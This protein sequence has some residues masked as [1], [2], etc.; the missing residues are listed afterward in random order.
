MKKITFSIFIQFFLILW[1]SYNFID[2]YV[3]MILMSRVIEFGWWLLTPLALIYFFL[4]LNSE[5]KNYKK[6]LIIK[7]TVV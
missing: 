5:I 6:E 7:Q 2:M 3:Y 4:T 1:L